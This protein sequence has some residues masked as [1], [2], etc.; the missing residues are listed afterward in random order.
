MKT[1]VEKGEIVRN[2][3][4]LLLPQCFLTF[5]ITFS[6]VYQISSYRLQTLSVWKSLKFVVWESVKSDSFSFKKCEKRVL[7]HYHI[8]PHFDALKIHNCGKHCE[9]RR[10]CLKQAISPFLT[11]FSTLYVVIILGHATAPLVLIYHQWHMKI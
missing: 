5:W 11:M 6:H 1:T 2:E 10:K 9:K 7:T 4:F 8:I 3:Q